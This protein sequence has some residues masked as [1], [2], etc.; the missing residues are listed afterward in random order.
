MGFPVAGG[1]SNVLPS[2][3]AQGI[4]METVIRIRGT[5]YF[6]LVVKILEFS[7][8][9]FLKFGLYNFVHWGFRLG[10]KRFFLL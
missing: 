5:L 1:Q 4:D 10:I 8:F 3:N 6:C 7:I 2:P 9:E